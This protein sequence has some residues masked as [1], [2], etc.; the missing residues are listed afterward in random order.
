MMSK[1]FAAIL[2]IVLLMSSTALSQP[3][4]DG[5]QPVNCLDC[6]SDL[7]PEKG[8]HPAVAMGCT[9]CHTGID[10]SD[11]P[12]KLKNKIARGLSAAQPD[13]CYGCHD[14]SMFEK[15][16]IHAAVGMGCTGCHNP[17]AS[18]NP[19]LLLAALPDL[20]YNCHDKGVFTKKSVHPPVAAGMCTSCH[21][22]H[23]SDQ[24]SLLLRP[25]S[26]LCIT[27]HTTITGSHVLANYGLGDVHPLKGKPDPSKAGREL[28]CISC[29]DPHSSSEQKLLRNGTG[30]PTSHCLRCH[31]KVVVRTDA[32]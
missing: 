18:K 20:C 25:V 6:H 26:D 9:A 28:S 16:V 2:S 19:K 13:L 1:R 30:S 5:P 3:K 4:A 21:S 14:R 10:A 32:P 31:T 15:K 11:M 12:H 23:S 22:P 24:A 8:A 29:H 17:H 27:C 7:A